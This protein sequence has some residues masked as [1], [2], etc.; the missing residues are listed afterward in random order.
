MYAMGLILARVKLGSHIIMEQTCVGESVWVPKRVETP[1]TSEVGQLD[2]WLIS[3]L[4]PGTKP[5]HR[6]GGFQSSGCFSISVFFLF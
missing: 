2:A 3:P 6:P 5:S 1:A 4:L